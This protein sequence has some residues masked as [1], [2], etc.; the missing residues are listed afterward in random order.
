MK[1]PEP[2]DRSILVYTVNRCD[3]DFKHIV[4]IKQEDIVALFGRRE[5]KESDF[6][7]GLLTLSA[8]NEEFEKRFPESLALAPSVI[9]LGFNKDIL[10]VVPKDSYRYATRE[11]RFLYAMMR[12]PTD[13]GEHA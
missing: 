1:T 8:Y 12:E 6:P 2:F 7:V 10:G 9:A 4:I 13:L 3:F 5:V 11:E